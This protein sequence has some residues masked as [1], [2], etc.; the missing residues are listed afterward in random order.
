LSKAIGMKKDGGKKRG[1][2]GW[3]NIEG[4]RNSV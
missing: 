3:E 2:D 1:M 4:E